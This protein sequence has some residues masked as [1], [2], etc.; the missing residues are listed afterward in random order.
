MRTQARKSVLRAYA[1][2]LEGQ[3]E[4]REYG[5]GV[6][7]ECELRRSGRPD[8]EHLKR[9]RLVAS[10]VELGLYCAKA[11]APFAAVVGIT[12]EPRQAAP[13]PSHQRKMSS[14]PVS[15]RSYGGIDCVASSW[16]R[17]VSASMS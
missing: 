12:R 7:E 6:E 10:P 14:R 16:I 5:L 2:R 15:Q 9:P 11:G 13:G 1:S 8:L 3:T 4:E 17:A